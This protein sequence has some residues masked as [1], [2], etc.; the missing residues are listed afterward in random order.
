MA[1]KTQKRRKV[2]VNNPDSAEGAEEV[3]QD[4]LEVLARKGARQ[5]LIVSTNHRLWR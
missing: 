4:Q 3:V 1:T 2:K 5:V